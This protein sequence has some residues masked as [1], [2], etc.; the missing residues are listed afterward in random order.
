[1]RKL[2]PITALY[3]KILDLISFLLIEVGGRIDDYLFPKNATSEDYER[4]HK[5]LSR[6]RSFCRRQRRRY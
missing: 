6:Y 3:L 5:S 4:A 1:M 2:N